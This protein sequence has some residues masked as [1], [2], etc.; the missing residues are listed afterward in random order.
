VRDFL[1]KFKGMGWE[2]DGAIP[3]PKKSMLV[4]LL[5][6]DLIQPWKEGK[7]AKRA[8]PAVPGL[9]RV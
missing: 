5:T 1:K 8:M 2:A 4:S 7:S 3:V 9:L 6:R